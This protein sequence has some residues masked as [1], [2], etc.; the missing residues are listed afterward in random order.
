VNGAAIRALRE[1]TG[2]SGV[3]FAKRLKI[4]RGYLANVEL[5][6]RPRVSPAIAKR[7]AEA[8]D[9]PLGAI[10]NNAEVPEDEAAATA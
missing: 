1:R 5:G 4:D 10:L 9:L 6:H 8:L 2:F 7:I 3:E